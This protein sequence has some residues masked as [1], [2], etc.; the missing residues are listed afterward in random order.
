MKLRLCVGLALLTMSLVQMKADVVKIWKFT[1]PHGSLEINL[2][3]SPHGD[4]SL[5]LGPDRQQPAAPIAE[6]VE[7]LK[8]VLAELPRLGVQPRTLVYLG[9]RLFEHDVTVKLAYACVDS[10]EWRA[11]MRNGGKGKEKLVVELLNKSRAFEGYNEAFKQYGIQLQVT[12][13]EKVWLMRFSSIPPRNARDRANA[14]VLV[15]TDAM[16]G[17]R[18]SRIE[19]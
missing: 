10:A 12:A 16:L 5:G 14:R 9:T 8:Q 19:K 3:L 18:F 17:M 13:A 1:L 4:Y 11:S 15:P 6:Q 2:V 7:P